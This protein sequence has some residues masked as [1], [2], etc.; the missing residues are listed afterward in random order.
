L[1]FVVCR[2]RAEKAR[3]A[4]GRALQT[5]Y[6]RWADDPGFKL[7]IAM[8]HWHA[9]IRGIASAVFALLVFVA[10]AVWWGLNK[11]AESQG[12]WAHPA[13]SASSFLGF[14]QS[15]WE[16]GWL[17]GTVVALAAYVAGL[18]TDALLRR[19]DNSR[20]QA[21][22]AIGQE[23]LD[24]SLHMEN[25][26]KMGYDPK[27]VL[28]SSSPRL[29]SLGV[30]V[31]KELAIWYPDPRFIPG[32]ELEQVRQIVGYLRTV[33]E[34]V[35]R[36]HLTEAAEAASVARDYREEHLHPKP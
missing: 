5:T 36:D 4:Q 10:P 6:A 21:L 35:V 9:W 14:L 2:L 17:R 20:A 11:L 8:H 28:G 3:L 24:Q 12:W 19:A 23:M 34:L 33:G 13:E 31:K 15:L 27:Y 29:T 7:E 32:K 18:W 22:R 30:T 26:L 16:V 25:S 1:R